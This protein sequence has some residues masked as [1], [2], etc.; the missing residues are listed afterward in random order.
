MSEIHLLPTNPTTDLTSYV[1]ALDSH[2]PDPANAVFLERSRV[3]P[4]DW[5]NFENIVR[6]REEIR[7]GLEGWKDD[8]QFV[9]DHELLP[10][11]FSTSANQTLPKTEHEQIDSLGEAGY[12]ILQPIPVEIRRV[13]PGDFLALFRE[14]NIAM[15][16]SDNNDAFQALVAEI[17]DTFD[18]LVEE[19]NLGPDA[20]EQLW[21]LNTY[22][23][24]T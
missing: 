22:I 3:A 11:L 4:S 1:V 15:S 13:E 18:V 16:G 23:V 21:I 24:R 14:A 9:T 17:L 8:E 19:R 6:V 20:A 7:P 10:L 12:R 5:C 2:T